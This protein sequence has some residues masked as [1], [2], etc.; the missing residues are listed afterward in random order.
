ML[1]ILVFFLNDLV[2]RKLNEV[3]FVYD[4]VE[5]TNHYSCATQVCDIEFLAPNLLDISKLNLTIINKLKIVTL[6][7]LHL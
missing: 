7:D 3:I 1:D 4:P 6:I 2:T 5:K